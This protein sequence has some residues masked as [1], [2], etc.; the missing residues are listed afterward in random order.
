[1]IGSPVSVFHTYR[2]GPK[3]HTILARANVFPTEVFTINP[4]TVAVQNVSPTV[5]L[6]GAPGVDEGSDYTLT[7]SDVIDP[8]ADPGDGS[9]PFPGDDLVSI[10]TIDWGD[11]SGLQPLSEAQLNANS[12]QVDHTY[13]G[14]PTSITITVTLLDDGATYPGGNLSIVINPVSPSLAFL[15]GLGSVNEG[16]FYELELG[17]VADLGGNS[18]VSAYVVAWDDGNS[19]TYAPD[20]TGIPGA[21]LLP[22]DRKITHFYSDGPASPLTKATPTL[23]L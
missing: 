8:G 20:I 23:S 18:T 14:G 6:S 11:G 17:P 7:I 22:S 9:I 13:A 2:D 4:F 3:T 10:Y 21:I 19:E 5:T 16:S 12:R 1:M 15:S